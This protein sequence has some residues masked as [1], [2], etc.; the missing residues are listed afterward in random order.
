[1]PKGEISIKENLCRGCGYCAAFCT[2][3]CIQLRDKIGP[4]GFVVAECTDPENCNACG[5]CGWMCPDCAITVYKYADAGKAK[6]A[7]R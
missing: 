5:I 2:K 3:G 6:A 7:Q 1:M 4:L